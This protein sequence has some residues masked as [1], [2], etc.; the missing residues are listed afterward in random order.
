MYGWNDQWP[1]DLNVPCENWFV[2][3][4]NSTYIKNERIQ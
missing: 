3:L 4:L 2:G 1:F